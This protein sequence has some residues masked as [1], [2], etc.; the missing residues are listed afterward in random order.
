MNHAQSS[1]RVTYLQSDSNVVGLSQSMSTMAID[2]SSQH[3]T[4]VYDHAAYPSSSGNW[5]PSQQTAPPPPP[6]RHS[7]SS[8][9]RAAGRHLG[10]QLLSMT[11]VHHTHG[12]LSTSALTSDEDSSMD[13]LSTEGSSRTS[14][15]SLSRQPR[16]PQAQDGR[17]PPPDALGYRPNAAHHHRA[18]M[19][20]PQRKAKEERGAHMEGLQ[21]SAT[22]NEGYGS[23]DRIR[24]GGGSPGGSL[25]V[26]TPG[27]RI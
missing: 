4:R 16:T 3:H 13:E 26:R 18:S 10:T 25:T 23:A 21:R 8:A 19:P 14:S 12:T 22:V 7:T 2:P 5:R 27:V 17:F 24:R 11:P 20:V 6:H 15:S 1:T 9:A